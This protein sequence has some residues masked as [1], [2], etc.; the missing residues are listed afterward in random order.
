MKPHVL[1]QVDLGNRLFADE[2]V[3]LIISIIFGVPL[4]ASIKVHVEVG[5]A[6]GLILDKVREVHGS[7]SQPLKTLVSINIHS[8]NP[9]IGSILWVDG[10]EDSLDEG[11]LCSI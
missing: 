6:A 2:P 5:S 1:T 4:E 8:S 10:V 9:V 7:S 11:G 3:I